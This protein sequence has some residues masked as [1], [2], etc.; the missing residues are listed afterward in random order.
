DYY[1]APVDNLRSYPMYHPSREPK[2]YRDLLRSYGPRPLIEPAA[3]KTRADWVEA[4]RRVFEEL[5]TA[6]S[7]TADPAVLA[8]FSDAANIDAGRDP[9]HDAMDKN[10][11][12]L[13]FRWVV[14]RDGTLKA[15]FSSCA[16][17]HTRLMPD[18]SLLRGAPANFDLDVKGATSVLEAGILPSPMPK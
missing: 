13:D 1:A 5:D 6:T 17:C 11:V 3:L 8:A 4:G 10:G 7:R 14:D 9:K 18:G 15:S 16:G 2:G 12:L